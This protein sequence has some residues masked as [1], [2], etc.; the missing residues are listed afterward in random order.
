M[1]E[2]CLAI[3]HRFGCLV[4]RSNGIAMPSDYS[5]GLGLRTTRCKFDSAFRV[6][7][8]RERSFAYVGP[9]LSRNHTSSFLR[10]LGY[11]LQRLVRGHSRNGRANTGASHG[12][13]H[14]VAWSTIRIFP[15]LNH[16]VYQS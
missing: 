5:S 13:W 8:D 2:N 16:A 9:H 15:L 12:S 10:G 11:W 6:D 1:I 3:V 7:Y 14:V 4:L